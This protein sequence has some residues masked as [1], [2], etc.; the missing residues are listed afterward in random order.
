M[1]EFEWD[2]EKATANR[3]KHGISFELAVQIFK[4]ETLL[5]KT[6]EVDSEL[7]ETDIGIADNLVI[8]VVTHTDREGR[9][10]I[11]SARKATAPEKRRYNDYCS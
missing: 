1:M 4:R 6:E 10:R 11:I 7:R 5:L 8:L 2:Q 3:Q 9:T